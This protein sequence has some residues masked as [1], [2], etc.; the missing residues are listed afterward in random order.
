MVADA[1]IASPDCLRELTL[2]RVRRS[3][4]RLRNVRRTSIS[5]RR[6]RGLSKLVES[7]RDACLDLGEYPMADKTQSVLGV[8]SG[9]SRA[10]Q[11]SNFA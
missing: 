1:L 3:A 9:R 6:R 10:R 5:S 2:D 7:A 4:L 11:R 8:D